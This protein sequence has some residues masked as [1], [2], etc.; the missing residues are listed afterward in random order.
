MLEHKNIITE[1]LDKKDIA[2]INEMIKNALTKLFYTL[3]I[4]KHF[5]N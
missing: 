4:K 2:E 1:E 5:L 3:Y